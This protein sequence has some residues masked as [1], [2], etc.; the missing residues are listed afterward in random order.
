MH[1]IL[2]GI[3]EVWAGLAYILAGI[4]FLILDNVNNIPGTSLVKVIAA[5]ILIIAGLEELADAVVT[6]SS[7][8][9]AMIIQASCTSAQV[10]TNTIAC[11]A[12]Y[13]AIRYY[14]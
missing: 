10:I 7:G 9:S 13:R 6:E 4:G 5:A 1:E 8:L 12:L 3:G 14:V 11:W 2:I